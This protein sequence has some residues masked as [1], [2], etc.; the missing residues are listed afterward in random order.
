MSRQWMLLPVVLL[1][2]CS[3]LV[4]ER[5]AP[6]P[7]LASL[8]PVVFPSA[9]VAPPANT[10][11]ELAE[12]N[13]DVLQV[14]SDDTVR[15]QVQHRELV[16]EL[17]D[18]EQ[19]VFVANLLRGMSKFGGRG[20]GPSE[21]TLA[22]LEP[23]SLPESDETIPERNPAQVAD[24][25][26]DVLKS[27]PEP[28]VRRKAQRRLADLELLQGEAKLPAD[29]SGVDTVVFAQSIEAYETLLRDNP[30]NP[31]NDQILYQLS[32]A[33]AL[34]GDNEK[35][36]AALE[37]LDS[38]YPGSAYV[39]EAEF[40]LA[41]SYFASADYQRADLAYTRVINHGDSTP[42]YLN[43]LYM[44]G[45]SRFKQ[46][47]YRAAIAPFVATLDRVMP[48]NNDVDAIPRG[49][50]EIA[51]DCLRAL[52]VVFSNLDGAESLADSFKQL[53]PRPYEVLLYAQLG[54]LYLGQ[55]RYRD[56][57]ETYK[58]YASK[59][60]DSD[61]APQFQLKV[62]ETYET[63]G[64][65]E[66]IVREKQD[67][68]ERFAVTGQYWQQ[69]SEEA[70]SE[71]R[72]HL[73]QF[74][75]ELASYYH[76][77][78]QAEAKKDGS[79]ASA[80]E[81]YLAAGSYYQLYI[82]SFPQD[83]RVPALAFLLGESQFEAGDYPGAIN[84]YEKVAYQY[85]DYEKA[86]DAAYAAILAHERLGQQK[87][88]QPDRQRI[89]SELRFASTF[90]TDPRVPA[91]LAHAA[92]GLLQL[93][94]YE[95]AIKF[96]SSIVAWKPVP[97]AAILASA[98]LVL[99]HCHFE[100]QQYRD[101]E[102][103]YQNALAIMPANDER[104]SATV[105]R[106]AASIYRQGE[107]AVAA[108]DRQ[109]AAQQFAR[110]MSAAPQSEIGVNAQF[111]AANNFI[112]AGEL[113]EG[114]R[115]L[116][117]FRSRY[118][119]NEL[120]VSISAI[121]VS[122]YEHLEQWEAAAIELD[123]IADGQLAGEQQRQALYLAASYYDRAGASELAIQ[124]YR[125][126]TK[127]WPQPVA[128]RMEAMNRL[129]ELYH[130]NGQE[131]ERRFWLQEM[132]AAHAE[133]GPGQSARSLYLAAFSTS[134]LAD[135]AYEAFGAIKL[136]YPIKAS[137]DSK[138]VAMER[139]LAAYQ[140]TAAYGVQ[141]FGT[142][143]TYRMGRIYQQFSTD[144]VASERPGDIDQLALEQYETLL[145]EQAYP[146]EEKAIAIYESNTRR[147]R[148]GVYDEWIQESFTALGELQPARYHKLE[149]S[150]GFSQEIY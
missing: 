149:K 57:A 34:S 108:G 46:G 127:S 81:H 49:Q 145:E 104:H 19:S 8:P 33:Y 115:L 32:R 91:V 105:D 84:T 14:I 126:Y 37:R 88:G 17:K 147:A 90:A 76:A 12:R 113:E 103:A 15:L 61:L 16:I 96:A 75:E 123:R 1:A 119:D 66:L 99:G 62:I 93:D 128:M 6:E 150:I 100:L 146:F 79:A 5:P 60:P 28:D 21:T 73:Q 130:S 136:R 29:A 36:V 131:Q 94:D 86:A 148:D 132:I 55:E 117:D 63:G 71:I 13:P 87:N 85:S 20:D 11:A 40:R 68:I 138:K 54:D 124:R 109:Q 139:A 110:V 3:G 18:G 114:N 4:A 106:V 107:S 51:Q 25:Y 141:Q 135:D 95:Q 64:F 97:D 31:E 52:A 42:Y 38:Q 45:W 7:T 50:L 26:R 133:A 101:A 77:V 112:Q 83:S 134:V 102:Q 2:A 118:P 65:P 111:D 43:A 24:A 120:S 56:S 22:D 121:L 69:R 35:S 10:V 59:F 144:L 72:P 122:N 82:D 47:D 58:T 74:I 30:D 23:V 92:E 116:L 78:A 98:W 129:A 53:G 39:P 70:R 44:Q 142:L 41:E 48:A 27:A 9:E 140:K 137:L 67:Y 89:D 80:R 125:S 143:A